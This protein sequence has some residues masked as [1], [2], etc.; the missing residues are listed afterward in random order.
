M[1]KKSLAVLASLTFVLS[2]A[3]IFTPTKSLADSDS[4]SKPHTGIVA[5]F[6]T[7]EGGKW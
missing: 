5:A 2:L 3:V 1:K 4:L 6:S 7:G